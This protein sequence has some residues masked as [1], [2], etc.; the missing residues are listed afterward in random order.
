MKK[1]ITIPADL[2]ARVSIIGAARSG[3]AAAQYLHWRGV[4]VF[5]S[6]SG[7]ADKLEVTLASNHIANIPHEGGKH[8]DKVLD[9]D[10]IVLSPGVPSDIP[11]LKKARRKGIPVWSEIELAFRQSKA[12]YLAVT[13]SSG[14]S[15]TVSML[16]SIMKAAG[17]ESVVA[18][19]IGRPLIDAAPQLSAE[20]VVVAEISS[21]QLENV[22]RFKPRV[23]CVIN[24][25]K[26]HLD[27]YKNEEEYYDAKKIIAT[28]LDK[29]CWLVVNSQDQLLLEW[30]LSLVEKTTV[31]FFGGTVADY[32]C[33]WYRSGALYSSFEQ[34]EH[35]VMDVSTMKVAGRHNYDNA[36]AAAAM[37]RAFGVAYDAIASGLSS[38]ESLPHRLQFAGECDGVRFYNDSK[39]TTAESVLCAVTA[40]KDNV[41]LIA[42]GKDKGCD[43]TVVN[44]T[45]RANVREVIL[46]GEATARMKGVWNGLTTINTEKTLEDAVLSAKRSARPG[47]VVV[48]SPGC[49]SYDMFKNYEERG[50]AFMSIVKSLCVPRARSRAGVRK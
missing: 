29:G 8:T 16:G 1:K 18:G 45:I 21:F 13:G 12:P 48:L 31:A 2:P 37:A 4:Q 35:R 11:I 26:N 5:V 10:L 6:D 23:A 22:D 20:G 27:R 9:T 25:M 15:T 44:E 36:A 47:D 28:N 14:K 46:I 43:F 32:P 42:G 7:P 38:F 49:S 3:I 39:S 24:L 41:H 34:G 50:E 33:V 40:F 17:R 30:A 19:N